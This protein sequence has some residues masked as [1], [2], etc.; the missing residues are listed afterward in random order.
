MA[1]VTKS[2]V[3]LVF[4]SRGQNYDILNYIAIAL[5]AILLVY[6]F[7]LALV[8]FPLYFD[9][10]LHVSDLTK[11]KQYREAALKEILSACRCSNSSPDP[12][13]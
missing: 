1:A 6:G 8:D 4:E 10:I 9:N 12:A 5:S 3:T 13:V 11:D 2:I 7:A